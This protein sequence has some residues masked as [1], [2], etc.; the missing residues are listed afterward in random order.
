MDAP[1][2]RHQGKSAPIRDKA[3]KTPLRDKKPTFEPYKTF[4]SKEEP[5]FAQNEDFPNLNNKG[6]FYN[7]Q[8]FEN[9][10]EGGFSKEAEFQI[11]PYKIMSTEI[12]IEQKEPERD[13]YG[14]EYIIQQEK[15]KENSLEVI[16]K[17]LQSEIDSLKFPSEIIEFHV[18]DRLLKYIVND[19]LDDFMKELRKLQDPGEFIPESSVSELSRGTNIF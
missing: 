10:K 15:P 12:N 11:E 7:P 14:I 1:S 3:Y 19:R 5:D 8:N 13:Y 6:N 4:S 17:K 9:H 2:L 16:S 18:K